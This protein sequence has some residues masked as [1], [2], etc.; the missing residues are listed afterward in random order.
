M[1]YKYGWRKAEDDD[2]KN[3]HCRIWNQY[4][5]EWEH[6]GSFD[7]LEF[8]NES[9]YSVPLDDIKAGD[10]W[11]FGRYDND[12]YEHVNAEFYSFADHEW[13]ERWAYGPFLLDT[14]YRVPM[15]KEMIEFIPGQFYM[16]SAGELS[17][18]L[19]DNILYNKDENR[20]YPAYPSLT[21]THV[22]ECTWWDYDIPPIDP[23]KGYR[24][25]EKGDNPEKVEEGDEYYVSCGWAKTCNWKSDGSGTQSPALTYRRKILTY[26]DQHEKSELKVGDKVTVIGK[27]TPYLW[28]NTWADNMDRYIGQT[29][30][31]TG[32]NDRA[33]FTVDFDFGCIS[34]WSF[35]CTS[36]EKVELR[37]FSGKK[38]FEPYKNCW[39]DTGDGRH[40]RVAAYSDDEVETTD[41]IM[42]WKDALRDWKFDDGTPFGVKQ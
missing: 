6:R 33:G 20:T 38:E 29:G 39:V 8:S 37:P 26:L 15:E 40:C 30:T 12:D 34:S 10:G 1:D 14:I 24:L 41:Y 3:P 23:G 25:L 27:T 4:T 32:D 36:L 7:G 18:S 22:P 2:Y 19:H 35:P 28:G 5:N 31:I 17:L 13:K 9:H 16:D 21:Y 42:S 11:R